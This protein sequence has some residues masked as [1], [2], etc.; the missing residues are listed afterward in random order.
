M[1]VKER[2]L[3]RIYASKKK[4]STQGKYA[5]NDIAYYLK[6]LDKVKKSS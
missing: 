4:S 2:E 6:S 5:K 1:N 3:K